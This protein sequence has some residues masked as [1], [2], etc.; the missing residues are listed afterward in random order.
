MA[1]L[2]VHDPLPPC[3][4]APPL[5]KLAAASNGLTG[6]WQCTRACHCLNSIW[7][8]STGVPIVENMK[9]GHGGMHAQA[10]RAVKS[11]QI[12]E[13]PGQAE[14]QKP[15]RKLERGAGRGGPLRKERALARPRR[16]TRRPGPG[17]QPREAAR[18][19]PVRAQTQLWARALRTASRNFCSGPCGSTWWSYRQLA[20]QLTEGWGGAGQGG[21]SSQRHGLACTARP[22]QP[23]PAAGAMHGGPGAAHQSAAWT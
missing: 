11:S 12:A 17:P 2:H 1:I 5:L 21:S 20:A 18:P 9:K 16:L 8:F 3:A 13:L 7:G 23:C 10:G 22:R 19:R 6:V 14:F 15:K 4:T